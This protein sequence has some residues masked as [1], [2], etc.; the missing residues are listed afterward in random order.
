LKD[1]NTLYDEHSFE[2]VCHIS[3]IDSVNQGLISKEKEINRILTKEEEK[4]EKTK[5]TIIDQRKKIINCVTEIEQKT[6]LDLENNFKTCQ[7]IIQEGKEDIQEKRDKVLHQKQKINDVL[8]SHLFEDTLNC[9]TQSTALIKSN[10]NTSDIVL[11][12][13]EFNPPNVSTD[14]LRSMFGSLE[15]NKTCQKISIKLFPLE[16]YVSPLKFTRTLR[17]VDKKA[18]WIICDAD[19]LLMKIKLSYPIK[20]VV[21]INGGFRDFD[22]TSDGSI[23]AAYGKP[24]RTEIYR[25]HAGGK[26]FEKFIDF[27]P[28]VPISIH[29]TNSGNILVGVVESVVRENLFYEN[30]ENNIRQIMKLTP[31]GKVNNIIKYN[32]NSENIFRFPMSIKTTENM[33]FVLDAT[34]EGRKRLIALNEN[35]EYLWT[36]NRKT[37]QKADKPFNPTGMTVSADGN[38]ILTVFYDH[39]IIVLDYLGNVILE[40]NSADL[41]VCYPLSVTFDSTGILWIGGSIAVDSEK[42]TGQIHAISYSPEI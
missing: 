7:M 37:I 2:L 21:K 34:S 1:F 14:V 31:A 15:N 32:K 28:L 3:A 36:F 41:G 11:P 16:T 18:A 12:D 38:V 20:E 24:H 23:I 10:R 25:L 19:N 27:S 40:K 42:Q 4:Y 26:K 6:L 33:I 8:D 39:L 9:V 35:T 22:L 30:R 29:V 5:T 17:I 13:L